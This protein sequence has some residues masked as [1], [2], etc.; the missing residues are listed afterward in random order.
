[1]SPELT[2]AIA[3]AKCAIA[4]WKEAHERSRRYIAACAACPDPTK[5]TDP[6]TFLAESVRHRQLIDVWHVSYGNE[7]KVRHL[8]RQKLDDVDRLFSAEVGLPRHLSLSD[9]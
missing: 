3:D 9:F 7:E 6:T 1:M 5:A 4:A 8:A 2:A